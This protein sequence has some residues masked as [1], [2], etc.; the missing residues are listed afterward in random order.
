MTGSTP[1]RTEGL[2]GRWLFKTFVASAT[3]AQERRT[4]RALIGEYRARIEGLLD[5]LAPV[6]HAIAVE[7]AELPDRIRGF[8]HVKDRNLATAR[9]AEARLLS[10]FGN[11]AEVKAAA[12]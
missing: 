12:E 10:A 9:E 7:I 2:E 3:H 6:N 8:G 5:R 4:E 11:A 1:R